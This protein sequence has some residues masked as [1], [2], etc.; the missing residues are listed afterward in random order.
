HTLLTLGTDDDD[1]RQAI[2]SGFIYAAGVGSEGIT[3]PKGVGLKLPAGKT[4]NLGLHIYNTSTETLTGTSGME[5]VAMDPKDVEYE[6]D[7]ALVGPFSFSLPAHEETTIS[8]SCTVDADQTVFS[9]FPHM[10]QLGTHIKTTFTMG[11]VPTV[12]HDGAYQFNEQ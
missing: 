8:R 4:L 7:S 2:I 5:V 1:C 10:H 9:L 6:A 3:L 11:G 12:V